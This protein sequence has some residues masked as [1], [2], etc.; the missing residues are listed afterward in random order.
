VLLDLLAEGEGE[1]LL[2]QVL[3]AARGGDMRAAELVL[4]RIWP[5]RKGRQVSL[6]LPALNSASDVQT[7]VGIVVDAVAGGELTT[8]E[9][10]ALSDLLEVKRKAIETVELE[11]RVAALERDQR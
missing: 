10:R 6:E 4:S 11:A 2:K 5:I 1:S 7:A 3:K 9:G 8:D